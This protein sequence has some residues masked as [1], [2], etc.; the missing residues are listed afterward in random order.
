MVL[1]QVRDILSSYRINS[2]VGDQFYFDAISQYLLKLGI[3]YECRAF[4]ANT[5]AQIFGN[6]KHL[7]VQQKIE[8]LEDS[9]LL[10]TGGS[11]PETTPH[12]YGAVPP[13]AVREVE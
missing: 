1:A 3:T 7:L 8:L 5:S 11:E 13:P 10:Q 12:L 9:A 2:V 4:G 6:L